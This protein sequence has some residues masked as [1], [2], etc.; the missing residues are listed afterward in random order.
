MS[1]LW[2]PD[3]LIRMNIS[4]LLLNELLHACGKKELLDLHEEVLTYLIGESDNLTPDELRGLSN[5]MLSSPLDLLDTEQ[6]EAFKAALGASDDYGQKIMSNFFIVDIAKKNPADLPVSFRLLGQKF[7]LDSYIFHHVVYD[8]II[9]EDKTVWRPLPDPLDILSV[10]GNEDAMALMAG[11]M[12]EY[13]YA[14]KINELKYLVD[15]YDD[16]FWA[17]SL[18]NSWLAAIRELNP[19][20][21]ADE[22]PYFMKTTAWHHEKLNTQLTSWAQL[23]HDNILYAKQSYTGGTSC[24]FPYT[25]VEPYPA[26]FERLKEYASDAAAFYPG[27]L[28]GRDD[29]FASLIADYYT[30]YAEIME[31]FAEIARKELARTPLNEDELVFLKTMINDFMASGPS[32]SGWLNDL[33]F[34]AMDQFDFD[35]TVADVHTQPTERGGAVVGNVLHVGNGNLNLGVF[36]APGT[37]RTDQPMCYIGPV[38][39]FHTL[40]KNNFYR[41][42]DE[43]WQEMFLAGNAPPRPEW[44]RHYLADGKGANIQPENVLKGMVYGGTQD[45]RPAEP[46]MDYLL[47]YPNPAGES[48]HLRFITRRNT[49]VRIAVLDLSGRQIEEVS[50]GTLSPAEHDIT[51]NTSAY[52]PGMYI[53]KVNTGGTVTSRKFLVE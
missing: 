40:V 5:S 46:G 30:R 43:E 17:S 36:I 32:I 33:Y 50:A 20:A 28:S 42:D 16:D 6:F 47:L 12:E 2:N 7:I 9:H 11:A 25:Y 3:E 44:V 10:L 13:H 41:L 8:R 38:G 53:L 29:Q 15:A 21:S 37:V 1:G 34:P 51:V 52:P 4:A 39:S 26:F 48:L 35:Y 19:P 49:D 45:I 22:L 14:Y 31:N 23:R 24:S 18:Y 27:V